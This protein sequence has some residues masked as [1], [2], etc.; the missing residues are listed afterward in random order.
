[1]K[2]K[3]PLCPI[4][5]CSSPTRS[6]IRSS[7][8]NGSARSMS[9]SRI[10]ARGEQDQ[11]RRADHRRHRQSALQGKG[12]RARRL[13]RERARA[14]SCC[15]ARPLEA[16][17][18]MGRRRARQ[19]PEES[20]RLFLALG[21]LESVW[22]GQLRR[23]RP[24]DKDEEGIVCFITVAGFLNGPG[25]EKMRDDLRRTC[26]RNLGHR[27]LA[28]RASAG[29]RDAHL[30]G[31][32]AAGLHRARRPQARQRTPRSRRGCDF[33]RCR[34]ASARRNSRHWQDSRWMATDWVDCPSGWRDPFLPAATGAWADISDAQ[35]FFHL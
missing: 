7:R 13:D 1:M 5:G 34:R 33:M 19:A 8:R 2:R 23:D 16:A 21:D 11:E 10:A 32:A 24:P 22:L 15:A 6:A 26:S 17:A 9:R 14:A 35:G 18:R 25:F 29:R 4:C 3:P 20:L 27:L 28:G 30:S 31:R 12:R